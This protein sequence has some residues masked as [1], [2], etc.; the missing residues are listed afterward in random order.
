M[1]PADQI[2]ILKEE[3]VV[4]QLH[5]DNNDL[6]VKLNKLEKVMHSLNIDQRNGEAGRFIIHY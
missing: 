1:T 6:Q 5:K 2:Q 3:D 4:E